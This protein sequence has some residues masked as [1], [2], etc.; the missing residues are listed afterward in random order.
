MTV[1]LK[2]L[3]Q[4]FF[5][6]ALIPASGL[7][8]LRI[9]KEPWIPPP[10]E[11]LS[12][13][14]AEALYGC[15]WL[16]ALAAVAWLVAGTVLAIFCYLFRIPAAIRAIEW[17]TFGPMQRLARRIAA[18]LLAIG[19]VSVGSPAG[20]ALLPPIPHV[21][22]SNRHA[23]GGAAHGPL[24]ILADREGGVQIGMNLATPQRGIVGISL[25]VPIR[26]GLSRRAAIEEHVEYV[27]QP[28]DSMWSV[29]SRHV[30]RSADAPVTASRIIAVW[31]QVV[32]L[33]RERIRSGDPD[34]IY[35]GETLI[36]P[37]LS[38]PGGS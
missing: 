3:S 9:R 14:P 37:G 4:T 34:L 10:G 32:D 7:L 28:G 36:L 11:I 16:A 31:R 5:V 25:P 17:M 19:S 18:A 22:E 29:S 2:T 33:N 24:P 27:V 21:V 12:S 26:S 30:R 6:I 35:P 1:H 8:L 23:E 20:A 38:F 15:V 13:P